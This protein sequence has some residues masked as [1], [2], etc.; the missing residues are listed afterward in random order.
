MFK[1]NSP[2]KNKD[3]MGCVIETAHRNIK[4]AWDM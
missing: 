4:P 2:D 3:S 1:R